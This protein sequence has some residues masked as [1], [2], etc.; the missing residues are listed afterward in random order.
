VVSLYDATVARPA[1]ADP[2][3][4]RAG[5]PILGPAAAAY[6]AAFQHYAAA[7]LDY[8]TELAYRALAG[9]IA[10]DWNWQDAKQEGAYGLA[11]ASLQQILLEHPATRLM[12]AN[13]RFDLVTPYLA[14]R[15]LVDQLQIPAEERARIALHVYPGGHMMYMRPNSRAALA[16]DAAALYGAPSAASQ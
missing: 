15:W 6:T 5:D 16:D 9:E 12:I 11:M 10:R 14:S 8:H 1:S 4:D 13:G 3:T 7:F 2:R